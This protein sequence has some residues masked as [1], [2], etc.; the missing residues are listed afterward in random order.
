VKGKVMRHLIEASEGQD[1]VLIDGVKVR[2]GNQWVA[3]IPD[4]IK[5]LMHIYSEPATA[6]ADL[7]REFQTVIIQAVV[8][9]LTEQEVAPAQ[10]DGEGPRP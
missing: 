3:M 1:I 4:P 5:P 6:A 7:V 10:S 9:G 8:A 2:R